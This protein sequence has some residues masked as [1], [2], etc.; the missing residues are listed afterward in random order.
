MNVN[1]VSIRTALLLTRS[2]LLD[3]LGIP[4]RS[5]RRSALEVRADAW[6]L[7]SVQRPA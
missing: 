4:R 7:S 3:Q 6:S 5:R 1:A 2:K